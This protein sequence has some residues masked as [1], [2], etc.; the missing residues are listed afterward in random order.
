MTTRAF[1][2]VTRGSV[3]DFGA[4]ARTPEAGAVAGE[5]PA[6]TPAEPPPSGTALGATVA[7]VKAAVRADGA[8]GAHCVPGDS[9][10]LS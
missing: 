7:G 9:G 8:A 3:F 2:A 6:K 10:D 1:A 5:V 4:E